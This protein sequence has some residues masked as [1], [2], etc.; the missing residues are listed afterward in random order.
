MLQIKPCLVI[1]REVVIFLSP[2]SIWLLHPMQLTG[3][4]VWITL[5]FEKESVT[6]L[7]QLQQQKKQ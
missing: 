1:K 4:H 3:N 5:H 6:K 2:R 7:T